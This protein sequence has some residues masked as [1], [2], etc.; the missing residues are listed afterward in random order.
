MKGLL[1]GVA[2]VLAVVSII[3]FMPD[4]ARYM[5]IRNM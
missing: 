3:R 5:K 2:V 1:K 4:L